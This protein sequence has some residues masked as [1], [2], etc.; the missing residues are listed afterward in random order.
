M[1]Y[2]HK[3]PFAG[4]LV[5]ASHPEYGLKLH[6]RLHPGGSVESLAD[7]DEITVLPAKIYFWRYLGSHLTGVCPLI[8]CPGLWP[9]IIGVTIASIQID[10]LH[11]MDLGVT[12]KII[13]FVLMLLISSPLDLFGTG[14]KSN[15]F[16]ACTTSRLMNVFARL[17]QTN[18][19]NHALTKTNMMS[20]MA[21]VLNSRTCNTKI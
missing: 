11:T 2:H 12:Q 6:D 21:R 13:G 1:K 18:E 9:G 5:S 15:K 20:H 10:V 19:T 3:R 16:L 14:F 8:E 17:Y 4:R 7:Y